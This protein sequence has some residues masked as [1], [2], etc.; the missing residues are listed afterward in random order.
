MRGPAV[1]PDPTWTTGQ[2]TSAPAGGL[3]EAVAA[4]ARRRPDAVALLCGDRRISYAELDA[5]A[6]AWAASLVRAG[7]G[8]GDLVPIRLPRGPELVIALLAVLKTGAAYALLDVAWPDRRGRDVIATLGAR[9]LIADGDTEADAGPVGV[10]WT[11]CW[12]I[13]GLHRDFVPVAVDGTDPCCVFFTSGTTGEPK[14][15]L[16]SHVATARLFGDGTGA[17]GF[18]R[19]GED[20]VMPLAAPVP[21]DAFSLELWGVLLS[22]GTSLIVAEPYLSAAAFRAGVAEHGVDSVWLTSSLFNMIVDEDAAAFTGVRQVMIGGERLSPGHVGRFLRAHP[23]VALHN[24]YGPV[25]SVVF[26]TTH[27]ITEADAAA[28]GGIPIGRPVPG[29]RIHVLDGDRPCAIGTTGEICVSGDGLALRYLGDPELTATKFAEIQVDGAPVRVYRT[30][31]L[32]EWGADGLLRYLG[33][34]DRQVK[35]RGHRV[36]PAEGERPVERLAA[37]RRCRGGA[38][39]GPR[40]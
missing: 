31:D 21:W 5:T 32:G 4:V 27:R 36:E 28:S 16:T 25:E 39:R 18:T 14:G 38:R 23:D 26:A 2:R 13:A 19:F 24:G 10:V 37:L 20:T 40:G 3:H 6:D 30:G 33:R 9:G 11:P 7:V 15:V 35:I 12:R 29:T 8:R 1:L 17:G 34:A 22:G